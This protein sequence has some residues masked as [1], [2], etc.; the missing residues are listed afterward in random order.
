[1]LGRSNSPTM[2]AGSVILSASTI[3]RRTR[4]EA[5]AVKANTRG[6]PRLAITDGSDR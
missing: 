2:T 5:V 3:S 6:R 1:M 4:G